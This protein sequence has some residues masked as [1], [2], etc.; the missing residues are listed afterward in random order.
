MTGSHHLRV[1]EQ[2]P[3]GERQPT[4]EG[5]GSKSPP[6]GEAS[7]QLPPLVKLEI[8]FRDAA[9]RWPDFVAAPRLGVPFNGAPVLPLA[10][11]EESGGM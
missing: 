11:D 4:R 3:R 10:D 2:V 9:R 5:D 7:A 1:E 6:A 8:R